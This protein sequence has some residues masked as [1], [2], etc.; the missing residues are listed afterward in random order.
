[1][2]YVYLDR[3]VNI[4]NCS[5]YHVQTDKESQWCWFWKTKCVLI[6][7]TCM[8]QQLQK[9][10]SGSLT[11]ATAE[12]AASHMFT[13]MTCAYTFWRI[14]NA[15]KKRMRV[16]FFLFNQCECVTGTHFIGLCIIL[17]Y[18]IDWPFDTR[19]TVVKTVTVWLESFFLD[20]V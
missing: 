6:L 12:N 18:T 19:N 9:A 14:S 3:L 11:Y 7:V 17:P 10:W 13:L 4:L 1:M 15:R 5:V 20:Y 2:M 16:L 8:L